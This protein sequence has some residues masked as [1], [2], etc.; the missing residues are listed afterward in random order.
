MK[1]TILLA[2]SISTISFAGNSFASD[3]S[4]PQDCYPLK[5]ECTGAQTMDYSF[6][7]NSDS[8]GY[9][10][11]NKG[12][13]IS[14]QSKVFCASSGTEI[15]ANTQVGGGKANGVID[16]Q[17]A[18]ITCS[19]AVGVSASCTIEPYNGFFAN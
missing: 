17:G 13:L 12:S 14:G 4:C 16:D 10:V 11:T 1:K 3:I 19:G 9:G 6:S 8:C 15:S 7:G 18:K 5:F 2:L